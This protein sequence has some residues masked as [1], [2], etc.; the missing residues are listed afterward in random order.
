MGFEAK[1]LQVTFVH[2][3]YFEYVIPTTPHLGFERFNAEPRRD[4]K[5]EGDSQEVVNLMP[6]TTNG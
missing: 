3:S 5:A 2:S 4:C 1:L 6:G